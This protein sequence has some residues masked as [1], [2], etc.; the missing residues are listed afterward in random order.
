MGFKSFILKPIAKAAARKIKKDSY[1]AE[2]LQEKWL[3]KLIAE[4]RSTAFGKDHRFDQINDYETFK[5]NVPLVDY[6]GISSYIK[7]ILDGE[8]NVLWKG[9]PIYFAKTSGTTSGTKY[10]PITKASVPNHVGS[11]R[12]AVFLYIAETGKASFFDGGM[13]FL[14]GSPILEKLNGILVGRLSGIVNHQIPFYVKR[15]Q[16]PCWKTN[17]IEDWELKVQ[18]IAQETYQKDMRLIGGIPPWIQ[19]YFQELKKISGKEK[20]IDLFP[21]LQL[22]VYGG[23][24]F[25]P[26]RKSIEA[27]IGKKID[28][29]ETYPASEGFIALQDSQKEKGLLLLTNTGIFY[30]FVPANE[31][32]LLNPTRITIKDVQIGVNYAIILNTNAGLF[33]YI[34]GDTVRFV[35]TQPHRIVV[36]GRTKHFISAFGEHVIGEEVENALEKALSETDAEVTEFHLAPRVNTINGALPHHEWL[37]EF[38]KMPSDMELFRTIIDKT[39]QEK[40]TYYKD[41]I[42]GKILQ[43]LQIIPLEKN[44]FITFMKNK[45]K[46]GGQNKVPRLADN[47]EIADELEK[48]KI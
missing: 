47:R 31:I 42:Q 19:M 15:N 10:I 48:Y 40:N 37:I 11:A 25:E 6:E 8:E 38:S 44:A 20:I 12:T 36:T 45:G 22:Y 39:L 1:R 43:P 9:K 4:A 23:T 32:H 21:N 18:T 7:R 30:E 41:L 28:T 24:N 14:S 29:I 27:E 5:K 34:I 33:G 3:K 17:C 26:Y 2:H 46:L 35:S 16:Q 13:M